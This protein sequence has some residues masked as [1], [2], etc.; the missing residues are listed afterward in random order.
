M[1]QEP[2]LDPGEADS[3]RRF[4]GVT[5]LL[6]AQAHARLR[7]ARIAV[8]GVGGVG[9]WAAE[10]LARCGVERITLIDLD[11]VAESNS[12][13]QI[14]A[15]GG[16]FGKAKVVAMAQRIDAIN[17]RARV[18]CVE[19]FVS[20]DNVSQLI[21]DFDLLLDCIDQVSAKAALIAHARS[22]GLRMITC[23]AAGGRIDPTRI[24][25]A[26]LAR[27]LGDPLLS[28]VRYRL[29]RRY[30]FP[31][32][33]LKRRPLF[34]VDA[35]YSDEPVRGPIS[36]PVPLAAEGP[37][38]RVQSGL[39]CAG[40]GSSVAV[41]APFGFAAAARAIERITRTAGD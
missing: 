30:Q 27:A 2:S 31:R 23:G 22:I 37:G 13:R 39:A 5:R 17:P 4:G 20:E 26:D 16:E 12:N 21:R 25:C 40:Y 32:E 34:G 15:L 14:Q 10:A 28:K 18:T 36:S 7:A 6:G 29:R 38:L 3:E 11:H 35:I 24:R 19:Q 8:V 41:T 33:T 1:Q 9:S